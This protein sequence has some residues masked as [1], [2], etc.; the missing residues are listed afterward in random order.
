[1][2]MLRRFDLEEV[3][4]VGSY[5]Q[6]SAGGLDLLYGK[7]YVP[8]ELMLIFTDADRVLNG[9]ALASLRELDD[10]AKLLSTPRPVGSSYTRALWVTLRQGFRFKDS[11][12]MR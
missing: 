2:V 1:M 5:W 8:D 3:P 7:N 12:Q 11:R 9:E 4:R 6:L 10:T